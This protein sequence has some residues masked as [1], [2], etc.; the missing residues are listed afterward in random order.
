MRYSGLLGFH[1]KVECSLDSGGK[2]G[3]KRAV[4]GQKSQ[5]RVTNG[6]FWTIALLAKQISHCAT[7]RWK[8]LPVLNIFC[9]VEIE[10]ARCVAQPLDLTREEGNFLRCNRKLKTESL[11]L[12][13]NESKTFHTSSLQSH[14]KCKY[15]R[16]DFLYIAQG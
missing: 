3:P 6:I 5:I 1:R 16:F 13:C 7:K 15:N 2:E 14:Q 12:S 8:F 11:K 4:W 10:K 9:N